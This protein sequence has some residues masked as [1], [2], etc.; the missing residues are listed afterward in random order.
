MKRS[1]ALAG[2]MALT[3]A[4]PAAAQASRSPAQ[5]QPTSVVRA[6]PANAYSVIRSPD[7]SSVSILFNDFS[8][9]TTRGQRGSVRTTCRIEAPLALPAG[10]GA[11]LTSVDYR[12]FA[13]LG[14]RQSADISA[15]YELGRGNGGRFNRRIQGRYERDFYFV[16]RLPPGQVRQAGCAGAPAPVLAINITLG[17]T[18]PGQGEAAM[19]ALDSADQT[20]APTALTYRFDVRPCARNSRPTEVDVLT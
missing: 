8:A 12:G 14:A 13:L 1:V 20:T 5:G 11:G 18:T 7:G 10:H 3:A 17:L 16:D 9:E 15:D 2:L 4:F 19:I 6:C